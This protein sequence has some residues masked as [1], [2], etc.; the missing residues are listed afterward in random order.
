MKRRTP[1]IPQDIFTVMFAEIGHETAAVAVNRSEAHVRR[2]TD[3]DSG[4]SPTLEQAL[5]LEA[6]YI[7]QTGAMLLT[8]HIARWM[9]VISKESEQNQVE[10]LPLAL[11]DV[12]AQVGLLSHTI[13]HSLSDNKLSA[14]ERYALLRGHADLVDELDDLKRSIEAAA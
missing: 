5:L 2:W 10:P 12:T 1:S 8:V 9:D 3:P 4:Q 7:R 13:R 6:E 14:D 11:M